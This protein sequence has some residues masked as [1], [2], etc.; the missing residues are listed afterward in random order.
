MILLRQIGFI[1]LFSVPVAAFSVL[2]PKEIR[3]V[4]L[5]DSRTSLSRAELQR[6]C[7]QLEQKCRLTLWIS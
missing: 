5:A 2:N 3:N 7:H 4:I 1:V 6:A